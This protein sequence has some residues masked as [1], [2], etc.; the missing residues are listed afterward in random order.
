MAD[1]RP[2]SGVLPSNATRYIRDLAIEVERL[3][4]LDVDTIRTLWNPH[5]CPEEM[6]PYLAWALS[7]DIWD[8][9]WNLLKK[10][11]V[12][13]SAFCDHRIKGTRAGLERYLGYVDATLIQCLTPPQGIYLAPALDKDEQDAWLALM[14]Q[15][16]IY[17]RS[18]P[19]SDA[20]GVLTFIGLDPI[21]SNGN[22]IGLDAAE[23]LYGK[24]PVLY[25]RGTVTP[26]KVAEIVRSTQTRASQSTQRASLTGQGG[27][28]HLG[29][30]V[31]GDLFIGDSGLDPQLFT[32]TIDATYD[33]ASSELSLNSVPVGLE[34]IDVRS[35][36]ESEQGLA[37]PNAHVGD[38]IGTVYL[39]QD[40][41]AFLIYDL[42]RLH[43][44]ARPVPSVDAYSFVG[45][46]RFSMPA[47]HAEAL[48]EAP[49]TAP[50]PIAFTG[51][52]IGECFVFA[53]DRTRIEAVLDAACAAKA[54]RD[55]LLVTFET[56]RDRTWADGIPLDGSFRLGE[57]L[58]AF[59]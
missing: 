38:G 22:G 6:L 49:D 33:H 58:P 43:D 40:L 51:D 13:A 56:T 32:Y 30:D 41:G 53:E 50:S 57:R 37:G 35:T 8:P 2:L 59:L 48:I 26:L 55:K 47:Y 44:P 23:T 15:L 16:R 12:V 5:D 25:D 4:D 18:K 29:L 11:S 42:I 14:P 3:L 20:N 45:V 27:H 31:V 19:G 54:L 21:G 9:S 46:S 39:T 24:F 36:R 52:F 10:R 34:P 7:V 28:S 1:L 17:Q